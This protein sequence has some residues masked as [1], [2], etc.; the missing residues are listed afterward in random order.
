MEELREESLPFQQ[1]SEG[2]SRVEYILCIIL[3]TSQSGRFN[4]KL[5]G[6]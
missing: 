3:L 6:L 4:D 1:Q 2:D 5:Q